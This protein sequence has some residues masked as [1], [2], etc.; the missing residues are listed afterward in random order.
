MTDELHVKVNKN[1]TLLS[2]LPFSTSEEGHKIIAPMIFAGVL[3][4]LST[5]MQVGFVFR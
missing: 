4:V 2:S 3:F 5:S 1:Q